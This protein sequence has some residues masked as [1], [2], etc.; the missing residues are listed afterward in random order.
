M[1]IT[2][3]LFNSNE[4]Q[5]SI[6]VLLYMETAA[7]YINCKA[8]GGARVCAANSCRQ[9]WNN[10]QRACVADLLSRG[11]QV[12]K[13]AETKRKEASSWEQADTRASRTQ[14][15]VRVVAR[16]LSYGAGRRAP[17]V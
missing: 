14:Q 2:A 5:P 7:E 1:A 9:R 13:G 11:G 12:G 15:M 16:L 10:M 17:S 4:E 6:G 8:G 3:R